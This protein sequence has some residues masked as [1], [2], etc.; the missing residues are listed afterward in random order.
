M[1]E[2]PALGFAGLLRQL[3]TGA[4][5]TQEELAE[6]AGLSPRSV[7]DL[8]RGINRTARKDTAELLAGALGL[9]EPVRAV[10]VT[11][12]RGRAPAAE[13]LAA[14]R[15]V[16]APAGQ[17]VRLALR[18]PMLAGREVLLSALNAR[19]AAGDDLA[20]RTVTLYGLAGTGK[21]S[22]AAEYAYR[23]LAEVGVAWQFPAE[24][25]MV[26]VAGFG[27]LAAQLGARGLADARD[28][29]ASVHAVLARF[30]VP[31][32]LIFDNAADI[33]SVA[34]FL[35]PAGP[36]QVLI[37]S[38][39]P[40]W[41]GQPLNVPVLD[42]DVAAGFLISR[43]GD[44]DRQ[45]ARDLA[46]MLGGLPL[47]LEQAA[48]YTQAIGDNLA[49]Y[50]ALYRQRRPEMLARGQPTGYNKTVASTW[51]LA[52]D[53]LQHT[54][55]GAVGLLR[56]LAFCA[57]D[58]IPLR[59]LLRPRPGLA[60][61]LGDE[62]IP[63]LAPL[64]E[65]PLA[66]SDAISALHRYSLIHLIADRSVSVHRLVQAVTID[67]MPAEPAAQWRQTAAAVIE[68]AM[69]DDPQRPETWTDFAALLRHARMALA[70]ES[71]CMQRIVS[72]VGFSGS[73]AA[74]RDLQQRITDQR[75]R[76]LGADHPDTLT[77]CAQL[78]TWTG[79]AGDAVAARDQFA[80]L[81]PIRERVSGPDHP[82]TLAARYELAHWTGR[83]GDPAAARD[84]F[85]ALLPIR[86]QV[87][88]PDHLDTLQARGHLAYWTGLAG[89]PAAARDQFAAILLV[90]E[91]IGGP[92][93]PHTLTGRAHHA[94]WTGEA[95]DPAAA[96]DLFAALLPIRER[97][98]GPDHPDTLAARHELAR[99]TGQAGDPTAALDLFAALLPAFEKVLGPIHPVTIAARSN[100]AYW[101]GKTE[102]AEPK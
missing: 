51:A 100:I 101:H 68:V 36:G 82:G 28:P 91:R 79:E 27:E 55:P 18:P 52:F 12:A 39:N 74:A 6:A 59:L 21:T 16:A 32:L 53:R 84:Q 102:D 97:V 41:P 35:P 88:G 76:V 47:A 99:W 94:R 24:D 54:E 48:A 62:V 83:T 5:L 80:A 69:P 65:D 43:T 42:L 85:A 10:F 7:S 23:H 57:P 15:R 45:T 33:S 13:V 64:L 60:G 70:A 17:P 11:A 98:S 30:T 75:A 89:N 61:R 3:R 72:Y 50:L 49:G 25:A 37:T 95:G 58:A 81:L 92:E 19:L 38:Q 67:Q 29:V 86:E 78:A 31:W 77:A 44:P 63:L 46:D 22:V 71:D 4:R 20:P 1:A 96:R 34:A 66:A 56:L 26:L 87:S 73:Y 2:Q 8:E 9:A 14:M 93:H 90:A 40:N